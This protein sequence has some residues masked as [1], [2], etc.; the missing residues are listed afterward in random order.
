MTL[1]LSLM[2]SKICVVLLRQLLNGVD[3][4]LCEEQAGF[5]HGKL[6]INLHETY[7][8]WTLFSMPMISDDQFHW[9]PK[10]FGHNVQRV[11]ME[12]IRSY[13]ISHHQH[14]LETVPNFTCCVKIDRDAKFF[15]IFTEVLGC[16]LSPFLFLLIVSF[17]M[18]RTT[19][20]L[21]SGIP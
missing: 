1:T 18:R 8:Y 13:G 10:S 3:D 11:M 2:P 15:N 19:N 12:T 14:F 7:H 16:V 4:T 17:G 5:L 9:L 6:W 20:Q 21:N